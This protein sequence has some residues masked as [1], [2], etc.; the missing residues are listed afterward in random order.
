ME[1]KQKQN[2]WQVC[3]AKHTSNKIHEALL[4]ELQALRSGLIEPKPLF[5]HTSSA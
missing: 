1:S 2:K 3:A 4:K 5:P